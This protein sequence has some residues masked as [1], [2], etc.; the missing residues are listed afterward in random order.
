MNLD[1][2]VPAQAGIPLL[3]AS[4]SDSGVPAF[5]GMTELVW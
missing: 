3:F 5:V 4:V 1:F 2:V